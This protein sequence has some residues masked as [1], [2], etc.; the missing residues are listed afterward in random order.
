MHACL[1]YYPFHSMRALS[2]SDGTGLEN[3]VV[4]ARRRLVSE[5][6]EKRASWVPRDCHVVGCIVRFDSLKV[7]VAD[8]TSCVRGSGVIIMAHY[9]FDATFHS[10]ASGEP[11]AP[12]LATDTNTRCFFCKQVSVC[13]AVVHGSWPWLVKFGP[14]GKTDE[15]RCM[16]PCTP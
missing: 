13:N 9:R 5:V 14:S 11:G 2:C 6:A 12:T 1:W 16:A 15:P 10:V 8:M 3:V 7:L 4:L